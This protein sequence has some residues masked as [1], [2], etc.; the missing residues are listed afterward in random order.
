MSQDL[1]FSSA[2]RFAGEEDEIELLSV[3]ID[4]GSSTTHLI[5]SRLR[6]ERRGSR[7]ITVERTLLHQSAIALTPYKGD[8]R[9]TIDEVALG[10]FIDQQYEAAGVTRTAVDTG[11]LILTGLAARRDN[12]RS[13]GEIFADE[14]G[15]F[16]TVSAGD[17]LE[18]TMAAHGSGAAAASRI[19]GPT[20]SID[21]G[22]GTTKFAACDGG[23]VSE[24]TAID[25]GARIVLFAD[26]GTVCHI[27]PAGAYFAEIA[28]V[29]VRTGHRLSEGDIEALVDCMAAAVVDVAGRSATGTDRWDPLLR[30]PRLSEAKPPES[31][32]VSGGVSAFLGGDEH[33]DFGDLGPALARALA[34]KLATLDAPIRYGAGIRATA[35]G[36]SQYTVQVSGSTIFVDPADTLPI[37]SVPVIAPRPELSGDVISSDDVAR[38]VEAA[39]GRISADVFSG[40]VAVAMRWE[41][42][43]S[44]RR[45]S[46]FC[47]GLI[48]GMRPVLDRGHPLVLVSDGDVGGLL[49]MHLRGMEPCAS[50]SIVSV[51][52]VDLKEFDYVDIGAMLPGS[53]A[54]PLVIKSLI[55]PHGGAISAAP[56]GRTA[57]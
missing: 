44:Y 41:G 43:A 9:E 1:H 40:A 7:Y 54:V 23:A 32:F 19:E 50:T 18:A 52:G 6:L 26:D 30:L 20:L 16:V 47:D 53:G 17:G 24:V 46:E 34:G 55:F 33:G 5:F 10:L 39:L 45:L 3:G 42:Q 4:I 38:S 12:A 15:R 51:D 56:A 27:E 48:R 31:V 14:A 49:G 29:D 28:G 8:A 35:V 57:R 37:R 21:V 13:V 2:G 36:A 25:V 22:G 11:A